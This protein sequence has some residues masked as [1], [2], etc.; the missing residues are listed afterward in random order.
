[1][2]Q[3]RQT[4]RLDTAPVLG[5]EGFGRALLM[6]LL[7]P[8]DYLWIVHHHSMRPLV[9]PI[10]LTLAGNTAMLAASSVF[11]LLSSRGPQ[12]D[13][14]TRVALVVLILQVLVIGFILTIPLP[15]TG[16][17]ARL[18]FVGFVLF[19]DIGVATVMLT[20]PAIDGAF[21]CALLV[22]NS[23]M[24]MFF[25]SSRWLLAHLTFSLAFILVMAWRV[26][27][28]GLVDGWAIASAVVVMVMA[29]CGVP[30]SSHI[31]WTLLSVDARQSVR[32]P[33]TGLFNR[34]GIEASLEKVWS[35]ARAAGA[36]IAVVVVDVDHF[37]RINDTFGHDVG[38]DVLRR[39]ADTMCAA[40]DADGLHGRSGGEEFMVVRSG[41]AD[42]IRADVAGLAPRLRVTVD[43]DESVD[44]QTVITVSVGAVV[45]TT[46]APTGSAAEDF[47]DALRIADALMYEAKRAG[48]DQVSLAVI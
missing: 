34:R 25:V 9:T 17:R 3:S 22:L 33:L 32:D 10:R 23:A 35:A 37:K 18:Y 40:T 39:L 4:S 45:L 36:G 14:G 27:Q 29:V 31:A 46:P 6:W 42:T 28:T 8:H 47:R 26:H 38:D 43:P 7:G 12:G 15:H 13:T 2:L 1:M 30:V 41:V 21:G 44:A 48:G 16:A 19:G 11:A 20:L 24:C 5:A